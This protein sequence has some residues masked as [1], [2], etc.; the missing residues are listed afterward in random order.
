MI[1]LQHVAQTLGCPV[2][3]WWRGWISDTVLPPYGIL[4]RL[5]TE[6]SPAPLGGTD[7]GKSRDNELPT[8]ATPARHEIT[9]LQTRSYPLP[10]GPW[11]ELLAGF[12]LLVNGVRYGSAGFLVVARRGASGLS[13]AVAQT[14]SRLRLRA[15]GLVQQTVEHGDD[16]EAEVNTR[17]LS[18]WAATLLYP[19][20]LCSELYR[21]PRSIGLC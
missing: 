4:L 14:V 9:P 21:A 12:S 5:G 2:G 15:T 11:S 10:N 19:I 13:V 8:G 16:G 6:E 18:S 1:E 3:E 17:G 7:T 20:L